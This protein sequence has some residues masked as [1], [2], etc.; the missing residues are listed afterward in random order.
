MTSP[1]RR[2]TLCLLVFTGSAT[3]G[4]ASSNYW[5]FSPR[6]ATGVPEQFTTEGK[7]A[8][9]GCRTRLADP[10]DDTQ[11]QLFRSNGIEGRA[12]V[13]VGDYLVIPP[14]KYGVG[15]RELLRVDC[16]HQRPMGVVD[17]S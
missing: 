9:V 14:G 5:E 12:P 10:R 11:L 13:Y 8:G 3:G 16:D 15:E 6:P 1:R 17:R 4:C 2:L 7:P